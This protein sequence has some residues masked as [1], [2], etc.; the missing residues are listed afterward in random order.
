MDRGLGGELAAIGEGGAI[1]G[2]GEDAGA[3]PRPDPWQAGHQLTE[4]MGEECLLNL[5]GEGV[6]PGADPVRF[7]GELG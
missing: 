3:G 7:G 4:K 5:G 6:A 1:A 2:L